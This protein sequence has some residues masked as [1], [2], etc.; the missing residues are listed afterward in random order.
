MN[1]KLFKSFDV[2]MVPLF[3]RKNERNVFAWIP[4]EDVAYVS[5]FVELNGIK[6]INPGRHIEFLPYTV[7]Q[8]QFSPEEAGNPFQTGS[9]FIIN[10]YS[11]FHT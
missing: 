7:G 2:R 10:G 8:A 11:I 1:R 9:D 6:N 4:K 5:R 3:L